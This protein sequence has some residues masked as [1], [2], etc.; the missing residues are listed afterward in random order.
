MPTRSPPLPYKGGRRCDLLPHV[1]TTV[2]SG[3]KISRRQRS[4][5]ET[6]VAI[7][8]RAG[9][10]VF[11]PP[12]VVGNCCATVAFEEVQ[13]RK[14]PD[15]KSRGGKRQ[16]W[17]KQAH[18]RS[19]A[20]P[21]RV[22]W[23]CGKRWWIIT[24]KNRNRHQRLTIYDF[25]HLGRCESA[26]QP[27]CEAQGAHRNRS[28]DVLHAYARRRCDGGRSQ[29]SWRNGRSTAGEHMLRLAGIA[30]CCEELTRS[31]WRRG[32]RVAGK[33]L[34]LYLCANRTCE[35]GMEHAR[36]PYESFL[37]SLEKS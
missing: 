23:A 8:H 19:C 2:F 29:V 16:R 7:S 31:A 15:G 26:A 35:V 5:P 24:P 36:A 22:P 9:Q 21:V 32:R 6:F 37:Y 20:M 12:D 18:C 11:I 1:L 13:C 10:P 4:L 34:D 28:P 14:Y 17:S 3:S 25:R 30:A 27:G 33:N